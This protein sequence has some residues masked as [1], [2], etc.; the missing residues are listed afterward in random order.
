M[1][2]QSQLPLD[3]LW[4][5][6]RAGRLAGSVCAGLLRDLGAR[7]V[8]FEAPDDPAPLAL[9][10][11]AAANL[12]TLLR[13]GRHRLRH[14]AATFAEALRWADVAIVAPVDSD[15]APEVD[16]VRAR[17]DRLV[18]CI[19]TPYGM[20]GPSGDLPSHADELTLQALTGV[21]GATGPQNGPPVA[22]G[23]A[24]AELM[25]GV[26]AA[27]AV[28]AALRVRDRGGGGQ[29]ADMALFDGMIAT[30]G[31]FMPLVLA[32]QGGDLRQGCRHPLTA[33][34][35]A[36]TTAD[37]Q[38]LICTTTDAQW[39]NLMELAGRQDCLRDPRFVSASERMRHVEAVDDVVN[40]WTV[41]HTTDEL[42]AALTEAGVAAGVVRTIPELT[43][44]ENLRAQGLIREVRDES[45]RTCLLAGTVV[46]LAGSDSPPA[47]LA[48]VP[49]ENRLPSEL[50]RRTRSSAAA[51]GLVE[52]DARE[53][54]GQ[55][56]L[57]HDLLYKLSLE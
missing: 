31:S 22:N 51:P 37:G 48:V 35:N 50:M 17:S 43:G 3:D 2:R 56:D 9:Q 13:A 26:N 1:P 15:A 39:R 34:W 16:A 36:F 4:V 41:G 53:L 6:E 54:L 10:G 49:L 23:V 52:R 25:G 42:I 33:P 11:Q 27:V 12:A 40:A 24:L 32:G 46:N 19:V 29:V 7:V 38:V 14:D 8:R 20:A 21:M 18:G 55:N 30:M 47:P 57:N 44:D 45:G 28:L 5:V